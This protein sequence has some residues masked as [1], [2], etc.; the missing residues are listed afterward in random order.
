MK[1]SLKRGCL[2]FLMPRGILFV[3]FP[4]LVKFLVLTFHILL[5][6]LDVC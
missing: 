2:G 6:L 3:R 5:A 1:C 4:L